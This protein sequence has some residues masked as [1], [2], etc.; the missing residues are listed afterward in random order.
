M[1]ETMDENSLLMLYHDDES[2]NLKDEFFK[3]G[4]LVIDGF[5]FKGLSSAA[6]RVRLPK[7]ED[8]PKLI[9]AIKEINLM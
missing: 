3:R 2:I 5:D 9:A 1:A 7:K 6:A 8:F 4:V